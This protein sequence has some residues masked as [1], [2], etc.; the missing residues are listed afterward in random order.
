ML[1]MCM[2]LTCQKAGIVVVADESVDD[3][4]LAWL[5]QYSKVIFL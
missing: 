1:G 4:D 2:D 3:M 5:Y